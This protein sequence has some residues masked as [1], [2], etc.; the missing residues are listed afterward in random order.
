MAK[1]TISNT[2]NL[3]SPLLIEYECTCGRRVNLFTD[4][5]PKRL[6]KCFNCTEID[7][8]LFAS[9]KSKKCTEKRK[10]RKSDAG[11]GTLI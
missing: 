7:T 9:T 11:Q 10:L 6:P 1:V 5:K 2:E 4:R 3:E 8:E